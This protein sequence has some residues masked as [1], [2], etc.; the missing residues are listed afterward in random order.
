MSERRSF[1]AGVRDRLWF[2][3]PAGGG[4]AWCRPARL[5]KAIPL[6]SPE[7]R[8]F[9]DRQKYFEID[10]KQQVAEKPKR[11]SLVAEDDLRKMKEEE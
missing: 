3:I 7:Q 9:R 10:V 11:V 6:E 8:S 4:V 2:M 1:V 5:T